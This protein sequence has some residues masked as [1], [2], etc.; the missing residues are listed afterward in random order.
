[1]ESEDIEKMVDAALLEGL[2]EAE[3]MECGVSIQ[4]E[5]DATTAWCGNCKKVVKVMNFLRALGFI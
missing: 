3:C 4:C 5:P 2:I 1:V